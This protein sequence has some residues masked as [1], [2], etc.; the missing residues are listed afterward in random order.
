MGVS[1]G[2]P[3]CSLFATTY[4]ER[5]RALIMV[6]TYA[7]R[8]WAPDYPWA[9]DAAA[10]ERFFDEIRDEL[11]RA[12]RHRGACAKPR[13]GSRLSRVVEQLPAPGR[14]PGRRAHPHADERGDRRAQRPAARARADAGAAPHRATAP[15]SS[16]RDATSPG[17]CPARSSSSSPATTICRS[18]AIRTPSSIASARSSAP[19]AHEPLSDRVLAT[20]LWARIRPTGTTTEARAAFE[21]HVQREVGWFRGRG[22]AFSGGEFLAAFDGPARAIACARAL[23]AAVSAASAAPGPSACTPASAT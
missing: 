17:S 11:G 20:V 3:L 9:P 19:P 1:E 21:A 13:R 12:G 4:P 18:S 5:T 10:R 22:L 6:G 2:G 8:M 23:A 16:M 15:C 7:K 14:E